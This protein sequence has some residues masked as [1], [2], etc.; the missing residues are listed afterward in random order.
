MVKKI[1]LGVLI[2]GSGSTLQNFIDQIKAGKLNAHIQVV[3][4]SK[5]DV[6]GL[7]R[8]IRNNIPTAVIPYS[9]YKDIDSFSSAITRELDRYSIDL[10][11]LAGFI[12][13]Y[14]IPEK[15]LGRIMNIH[16]AL[17]P[18]FSGH[19]YYG[20]KVHEAVVNS[21]V[22]VSGCTVHFADNTYDTG[23]IILQRAVPVFFED[24]PDTLAARVLK[25]EYEAYPEAIR[26]FAEGRL[27]RVGRKVKVLNSKENYKQHEN[28]QNSHYQ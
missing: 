10:I 22:K 4:S 26:L 1:Q 7:D 16:P 23:P 27:Q 20:R 13:L 6:A 25:E 18:A 17:I 15:Y 12:H 28:S 21:G 11:A 3:I 14:K 24:T 2:S 5:Y 19:G 9:H 8:A